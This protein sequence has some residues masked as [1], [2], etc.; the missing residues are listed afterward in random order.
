[1]G[2]EFSIGGRNRQVFRCVMFDM[3]TQ[4]AFIIGRRQV[5]QQQLPDHDYIISWCHAEGQ[6]RAPPAKP[7]TVCRDRRSRNLPK[8]LWVWIHVTLHTIIAGNLPF[9]YF[10]ETGNTVSINFPLLLRFKI[11]GSHQHQ[12]HVCKL[13]HYRIIWADNLTV[14]ESGTLRCMSGNQAKNPLVESFFEMHPSFPAF[15]FFSWLKCV[16]L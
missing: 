1:M 2:E 16:L 3:F 6:G 15:I 7:N 13:S 12:D 10:R 5:W 8:M 11:S 9:I 4:H 14:L